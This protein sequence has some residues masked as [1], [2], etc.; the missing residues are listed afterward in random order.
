M[1]RKIALDTET[2]GLDINQGHRIIS[3]GCVEII[4]GMKTGSTIHL[5]LNPG[6]PSDPGAIAVHGI[7]DEFLLNKPKFEEV[8]HDFL[9]FIGDD[10][11]IIHN[12]QFDLKFL[13]NELKISGIIGLEK[14][15]I[16][17]TLLLSRE[18]YPGSPASLDALCKKFNIDNSE[19]TLHGALIDAELL[20]SVY[21]AMVGTVQSEI[22]IKESSN[23]TIDTHLYLKKIIYDIN[24]R[25]FN[26]S[27]EDL[28]KHQESVNKIE[29]SMWKK[30]L[31]FLY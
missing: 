25:F 29:N 21:I 22:D 1:I 31:P 8:A 2:T 7:K 9:S 10:I 18:R 23:N 14:N 17:D 16:I 26:I 28:K 3:I 13:R 4:N 19:R 12:A 6:R 20:A 5:M 30:I 24:N 11:L 15:H 27:Q